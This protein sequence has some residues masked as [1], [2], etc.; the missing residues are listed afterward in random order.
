MNKFCTV[1]NFFIWIIIKKLLM[2]YKKWEYFNEDCYWKMWK[3][4]EK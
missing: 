1:V 3:K 2:W 4:W